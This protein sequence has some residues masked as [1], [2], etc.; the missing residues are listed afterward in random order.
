MTAPD[1]I[2]DNIPE[3][4]VSEVASAVKRTV[5][6]AFD[7]VRVRGEISG[8][9][10]ARSGHLYL[11]L[12]DATAVLDSVVWRG[13]AARLAM[14]PEDGLE[15]VCEGRLSTY[16]QRS[17]Y[18]LIVESMTLAGAG[19]LLALLE[20]RRRKL[21]DEGLFDEDRKQA[22]PHLPSRIGVVTSP[23]G[24]AIRDILQ[25]IADRFP[26]PV[27]VWPARVQGEGAALEI[28]RAIAGFNALAPGGAVPRPDVLIVARGGGSIEDLWAFNEEVVVRAAVASA[29]PLISAVGH[30]TDTTL[31]DHAAD[32]RAPTP[33]A[34]AEKAVPVRGT[35]VV[36]VRECDRR[37]A[38]GFA[39][40]VE[41][42]RRILEGLVRG[43]PRPRGVI[44]EATQRLDDRAANLVRA[45][46]VFRERLR[47]GLA[48]VHHRLRSPSEQT[49]LAGSR[50]RLAQQRFAAAAN[51]HNARKRQQFERWSRD[52]RLHAAIRRR[53]DEQKRRLDAMTRRLES[54]SYRNVLARGYAV[55]RSADAIVSTAA[56]ARG[57]GRVSIEFHDARI[58]ARIA[59]SRSDGKRLQD[60]RQQGR[61]L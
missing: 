34:A 52:A 18:Q 16:A 8:F 17:R 12:K 24:A 48:G 27:W 56:A 40:R 54:V 13:T 50:Y 22:I 32:W 19:A 30:E 23:A 43:L 25:R 11:S 9:S 7:R 39:R 21:A 26:R 15:V 31:I 29:I 51:A 37:L 6:G 53:T 60:N 59:R 36:D 2:P 4:S 35:L 58:D 5:E 14:Q 45:I 10:R 1:P 44:D 28:A 49:A 3:Y 42:C 41:S 57:A 20:E 47:T 46:A 38:A 33:T 61:L 55:V